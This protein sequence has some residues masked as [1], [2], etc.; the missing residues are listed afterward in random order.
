MSSKKNH[1]LEK[2]LADEK[3][4]FG[5]R[6]FSVGVA[7][8]LLG[9]SLMFG[10]GSQVAHADTNSDG[11]GSGDANSTDTSASDV[12]N[13]NA[14][15]TTNNYT[16]QSKVKAQENKTSNDKSSTGKDTTS[17]TNSTEGNVASTREIN[18]K[19][20]ESLKK[21]V[22][23][24]SLTT[25][26]NNQVQKDPSDKATATINNSAQDS[27]ETTTLNLQSVQPVAKS[28]LK[29]YKAVTPAKQ[30]SAILNI[31]DYDDVDPQTPKAQ[32]GNDV[33]FTYTGKFTDGL[34]IKD[35]IQAQIDADT[36]KQLAYK[37]QGTAIV[38]DKDGNP[39]EIGVSPVV[40][41]PFSDNDLG[42]Y[43]F[44]DKTIDTY[45]HDQQTQ[46]VD[47]Y[48]KWMDYKKAHFA[49]AGYKLADQDEQ[50]INLDDPI[51]DGKTYNIY[52]NHQISVVNVY[53]WTELKRTVEFKYYYKQNDKNDQA[54]DSVTKNGYYNDGKFN[55]AQP[56]QF[57]NATG[58][59]VFSNLPKKIVIS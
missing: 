24:S 49:L 35:A 9:T 55:Q 19:K 40:S 38:P 27:K 34:S 20:T 1:D 43:Y 50:A 57:I 22:D 25:H 45:Q 18:N 36:Q 33:A 32:N 3:Q 10:A 41:A 31:Y 12:H 8:V 15:A 4:R 53:H 11:N 54:A 56:K 42:G 14:Q 44:R 58:K 39:T 23:D 51:E 5:I 48:N 16:T 2:N 17:A 29:E 47:A 52:V 7:S 13:R 28:A 59:P 6:K 21:K 46:L 30:V 37:D 26:E